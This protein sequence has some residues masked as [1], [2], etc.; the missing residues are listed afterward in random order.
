MDAGT[1]DDLGQL[2]F[3]LFALAAFAGGFVSGLSGFAMG[4]IVSGMWLHILTPIQTATLIAGYGLL[5]QGFGVF[6]L[7]A[8]LQWRNAWP[9]ALGTIVGI[10]I[11]ALL[12]AQVN[13]QY[14]RLTVGMVLVLYAIYGL[15]RP[16]FPR[17]RIGFRADVLIGMCN[18][19]LGGLTG[20]GGV[21]STIST[22]WRGWS[23]EQQRAVFQPVLLVAFV[24]ITISHV[25][26]GNFTL[27]TLALFACG[28]PFMVLGLWVGFRL[29]GKINDAAFRKTV[30]VLL[31]AAGVSL[32]G[33]AVT[34]LLEA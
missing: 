33:S 31:L 32:L 34:S 28:L 14:L 2:S 8:S 9:L 16:I 3:L 27:E 30:L 10:P 11:G 24:A 18:G 21:I 15:T 26:A 12:L 1:F 22:Q 4:L 20:L 23:K 19:V 7:R 5:T 6:R 25:A 29:F 13:A 17:L